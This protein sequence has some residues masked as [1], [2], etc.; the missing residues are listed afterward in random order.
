MSICLFRADDERMLAGLKRD[1]ESEALILFAGSGLSA[2]ARTDAGE[3]PPLW[4][5]M[6]SRMIAWCLNRNLLDTTYAGELQ[7]AVLAGLLLEVGEELQD[8]F[9]DSPAELQLCLTDVLLCRKARTSEAHKIAARLPFRAYLTTNYDCF[10]EGAYQEERRVSID[11]FYPA[12]SA[13]AAAALREKRPFVFKLHGDVNSPNPIVL[14]YRS[15]AELQ[16]NSPAYA[17][18]VQSIIS[19]SSVLFVGFSS[20]DPHI[21]SIIAR[22]AAFDGRTRRHWM[23]LPEV[24]LLK[25]KAKRF[26]GQFGIRVVCYEPDDTHSGLERFLRSIEKLRPS[27]PS[28]SASTVGYTAIEYERRGTARG[29]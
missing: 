15:Y 14:G 22:V 2:Q 25:F 20:S 23:V 3:H 18:S 16:Y 7:E 9:R 26:S 5:D 24:P 28:P 13:G 11:T 12:T 1:L 6:L 27:V 4:R 17:Q 8:I 19:N 21:E 10:L 29:R